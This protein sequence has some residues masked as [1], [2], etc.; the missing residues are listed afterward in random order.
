MAGLV[1]DKAGWNERLVAKLAASH[2][3]LSGNQR[4]QLP[5][6]TKTA[7]EP[8]LHADTQGKLLDR[9]ESLKEPQGVSY[10]P[11][12]DT[13]YV[14]SAGDGTLRRYAGADFAS[15][16][17]TNLGDDADNVH[18]DAKTGQIVVGYGDGA[19]ALVDAASGKKNG[20][21]ALAAH[22][23]SFRIEADGHRIFVNVPKAHEVAVV[24]RDAGKQVASW[25]VD[26]RENF[27]MA[28]DEAGGR[29]L[30]VDQEPARAAGFRYRLRRAC[31]ASCDLR[32]C[33]RRLLGRKAPACLCQL[34]RGLPG[35]RAATRRHLREPGPDPDGCRRPDRPVRAR[36]R[37]PVCGRAGEQSGESGDLGFS[38]GIIAPSGAL[39]LPG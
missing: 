18:L 17:V 3:L 1:H 37:P 21:I 24:D 27:P 38:T 28:L 32:R 9:I 30:I 23:E 33:R 13:V 15:L 36:T 10:D 19:L 34:R 22:P 39:L 6:V 16:G 31:G 5:D 12:S 14:A 35:R 29:L 11:G 8:K 4:R 25:K 26:G 2:W 20:D 7:P